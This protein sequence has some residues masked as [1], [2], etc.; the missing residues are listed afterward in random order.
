MTRKKSRP[1][2][3]TDYFDEIVRSLGMSRERLLGSKRNS[4]SANLRGT[5]RQQLAPI[6]AI[7]QRTPYTKITG[8]VNQEFKR[9]FRGGKRGGIVDT[10]AA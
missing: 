5:W 6:R 1:Q 4:Q 8:H 2:K 7:D 9:G 3:G 10:Q